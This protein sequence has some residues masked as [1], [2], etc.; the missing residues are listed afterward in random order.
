MPLRTV[1]L[2]VNTTKNKDK[3]AFW[4]YSI[5]IRYLL[6]KMGRFIQGIKKATPFWRYSHYGG[7]M[8]G[9]FDNPIG[10]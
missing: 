8:F 5:D 4:K 10:Y 2:R 3:L 7:G 6:Q 9:K 1:A